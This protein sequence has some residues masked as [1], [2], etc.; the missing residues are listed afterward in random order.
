[1]FLKS[2]TINGKDFLYVLPEILLL[3][4]SLHCLY[5]LALVD[6]QNTNKDI[7][8]IK[9]IRQL[10]LEVFKITIRYLQI[11]LLTLSSFLVL[12]SAES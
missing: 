3:L 10:P 1:M 2:V 6:W 9:T 11:A 7:V 5:K 8:V 4:A 12:I